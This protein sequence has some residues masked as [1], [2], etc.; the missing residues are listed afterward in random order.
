M[1]DI[2]EKGA[3]RHIAFNLEGLHCISC[4]ASI[5]KA[6]GRIDGVVTSSV[7]PVSFRLS[8]RMREDAVTIGLLDSIQR[9]VDGIETGV[10]VT[11]S[12]AR[13]KKTSPS[14]GLSIAAM[15]FRRIGPGLALWSFA[16]L[17]PEPAGPRLALFLLAYL[18][19][20]WEILLGAFRSALSGSV[21]NEY[22]L[23]AAAT[24]GAMAI[25]EYPEAVAVMLFFRTGEILEEAA[26]HRATGSIS[27]L[28]EI[29]PDSA[30]L[31]DET[32]SVMA[33]DPGT[34][35]P[36][37]LV[38]VRPGERIPVDGDVIEGFSSLDTSS[39]TGESMPRD[40]APGDPV[41]SGFLN[42]TGTL[43]IRVSR[44]SGSSAAQRIVEAIE[45]ARSRKSRSERLITSFAKVYT[46][47]VIFLA[48]LLASLPPL[49]G[50]GSF[51]TWLYRALVFLVASCPCA[52]L[53]SIPLGVFAGIGA[54]SGRGILVKGGDVLE[55]LGNVDTVLFDK[56]GT[57]TTGI[58]HLAGLFPASGRSPESLLH[59][60]AVAEINSN[61]PLSI[62]VMTAW[63]DRNPPV[64]P[65][66]SREYPGLGVMA[67]LNGRK[68]LA[69]NLR[70]MSE[71]GIDTPDPET[72]GT[73]VHVAEGEE[74]AGY[75]VVEDTL[76]PEAKKTVEDLRGMGVRKIFL[77]SGDRE[78]P[79]SK[80]SGELGLD[81]Y[82]APL[83]P[84]AKEDLVDE[85]LRDGNP[86][87]HLAFVG[88][89]LNDAP[90]IARADIGISMGK[91]ASDVTFENADVSILND[92]PSSL[93]KAMVIAART[94][95]IVRQNIALALGVK[96]FVLL[97]GAL[98][99]A[100]LWEAVFA[101]VGVTILAV[102]NSSRAFYP[103]PDRSVNT[104]ES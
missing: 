56:T 1:K 32:G 51:E 95:I 28:G 45:T 87:G 41:L 86:R 33:A 80:I 27:S 50:W 36:G 5:G 20:G 49:A 2:G 14:R 9:I 67:E 16:A 93:V 10:K 65:S 66:S 6:A 15:I 100:T 85:M 69:G 78:L 57:L 88:D 99:S 37:D 75:L 8:L 26:V 73:V 89:G 35:S 13:P 43:R 7:D 29:M 72:A 44:P 81:G 71:N 46:P 94:R 11:P 82:F 84:E 42:L 52:L 3:T 48:F 60:A 17:L 4:A 64:L 12:P 90:V 103:D 31:I 63:G 58:F 47:S 102:L 77:L 40:S 24:A 98:G 59:L 25:G 91:T 68:I 79:A 55:R 61:H 54:A 96:A 53:I 34:L 70:F 18:V 92:E 30:N 19:S 39:I 62:A 74:Y 22:L 97:S 101:D 76:K 83:L 38:L 23:M 104:G 21:F